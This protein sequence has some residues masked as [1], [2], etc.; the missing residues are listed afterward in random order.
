MGWSTTYY[1]KEWPDDS[2]TLMTENGQVVGRFPTVD[3]AIIT[4]KALHEVNDNHEPQ[5][6]TVHCLN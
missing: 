1:V 2:A 3:D 4:C 5:R 6:Y